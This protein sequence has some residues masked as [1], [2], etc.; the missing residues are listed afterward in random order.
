MLHVVLAES[1]LELVPPE[2]AS[3]PQVRAYAR[4]RGKKAEETLLDATYHYRAMRKLSDWERR[5]RP[6]IVH[7]CL[8]NALES[9]ANKEGLLRLYVHTRNDEVIHVKPET[10]IPKNYNRFVGL[11]EELFRRGVVPKGLELLRMERKSLEELLDELGG[12][13]FILHEGGE[14]VSIVD[15]VEVLEGAVVVIGGFPHGDFKRMPRGRRV[16]IYPKPL[17][18][19]SVLNEVVVSYGHFA[20]GKR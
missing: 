14:P 12:E 5:G 16:S 6:D 3:H 11:M 10:R 15:L 17:T 19:W 9:I 20:T 4:K 7:V 2:I 1:E 13:V 18:A 8:L